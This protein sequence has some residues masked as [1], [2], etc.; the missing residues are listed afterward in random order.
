MVIKALQEHRHSSSLDLSY[1]LVINYC[2]LSTKSSTIDR[3]RRVTSC[4]A[5][6]T[7]PKTRGGIVT[8][9]RRLLPIFTALALLLICYYAV[10]AARKP[11][12]LLN[13]VMSQLD[14]PDG[15]CGG[16]TEVLHVNYFADR[17]GQPTSFSAIFTASGGRTHGWVA[18]GAGDREVE[19]Y[20][21]AMSP[22]RMYTLTV[23]FPTGVVTAPLLIYTTGGGCI[24]GGYT[25]RAGPSAMHSVILK[26]LYILVH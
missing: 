11:V 1:G 18:F 7:W 17:Q 5:P 23:D 24:L 8:N 16:T 20:I 10:E 13:P 12:G 19:Q 3:Q 22:A 4:E 26:Q 2:Y 21:P 9:M 25:P 14:P 15:F 6:A